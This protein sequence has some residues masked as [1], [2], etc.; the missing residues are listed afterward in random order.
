MH[1]T[2]DRETWIR[3]RYLGSNLVVTGL[4][5]MKQR[6]VRFPYH[7]EQSLLTVDPPHSPVLHGSSPSFQIHL[8]PL[9]SLVSRIQLSCGHLLVSHTFLCSLSSAWNTPLTLHLPDSDSPFN[10]LPLQGPGPPWSGSPA[11]PGFPSAPSSVTNL[12]LLCP[13]CCSLGALQVPQC[14]GQLLK[15]LP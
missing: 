2:E 9:I 8:S 5:R 15:A 1:N 10:L 3:N 11:I 12:S 14:Q 13:V 7:K 6:G 4:E